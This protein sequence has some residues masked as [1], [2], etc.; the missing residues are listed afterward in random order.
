MYL[1]KEAKAPNSSRHLHQPSCRRD[2]EPDNKQHV[3]DLYPSSCQADLGLSHK[4][5][6]TQVTLQVP[7]MAFLLNMLRL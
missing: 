5:F 6:A 3:E 2:L 1:F 4:D 7:I